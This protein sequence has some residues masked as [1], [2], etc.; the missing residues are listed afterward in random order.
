MFLEHGDPEIFTCKC[1]LSYRKPSSSHTAWARFKPL[2][3][4][5]DSNDKRNN[6]VLRSTVHLFDCGFLFSE[7]FHLWPLIQWQGQWELEGG[8]CVEFA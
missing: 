1:D 8:F 5:S 6:L 3:T 2:K 4:R 7:L